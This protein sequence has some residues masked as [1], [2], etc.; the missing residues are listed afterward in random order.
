ME[1]SEQIPIGPFCT[2]LE[3]CGGSAGG[4]GVEAG[5]AAGLVG[6]LL[7]SL[8]G[9]LPAVKRYTNFSKIVIRMIIVLL[10]FA[11]KSPAA[12]LCRGRTGEA[13]AQREFDAALLSVK[14]QKH[15]HNTHCTTTCLTHDCCSFTHTHNTDRVL[16]PFS[17]RALAVAVCV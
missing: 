1:L 3:E 14:E 6:S 10:T 4:C 12:F 5:A 16:H 7:R 2:Y 11:A 13:A 15:K 9:A 17:W 8:C